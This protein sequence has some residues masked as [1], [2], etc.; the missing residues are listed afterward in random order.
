V[1]GLDALGRFLDHGVARGRM[2]GAVWCVTD[3]DGVRSAGALGHAA[4]EPRPA[5]LTEETPFD[6]ASL[7]KPLCTALLL[8]LLEAERRLDSTLPA[9]EWLPELRGS[10]AGAATL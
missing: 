7:T 2:P 6:L 4:L 10:A 8:V 1:S 3:G 5:A 9:E